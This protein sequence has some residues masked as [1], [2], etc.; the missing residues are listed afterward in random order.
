MFKISTVIHKFV[1]FSIV[2]FVNT[3]S[4]Y[5]V[6]FI[7]LQIIKLGYLLSS[8]ISY[9]V[10]IVISYLGNKYWTFQIKRSA[11]QIEFT[12]FLILNIIGLTIN[13]SIM[14]FLV[15]I[16]KL[17]PLLAQV[18]AMSIVIFYNFLGSH[19]WVFKEHHG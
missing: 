13:T 3:V 2:G 18:V 17:H 8:I 16:F 5:L 9:I 7:L 19:Y 10:G 12:K 4:S 6:F 15:E 1:K 14:V 11:W